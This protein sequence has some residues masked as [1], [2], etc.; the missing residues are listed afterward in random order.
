MCLSLL[1][2]SLLLLILVELLRHGG[3]PG[4]QVHLGPRADKVHASEVDGL[5]PESAISNNDNDIDNNDKHIYIY[6]HIYVYIYI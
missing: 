3:L 5:G 1:S 6:I 4:G 2:S